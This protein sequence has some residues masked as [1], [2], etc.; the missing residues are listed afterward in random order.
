MPTIIDRWRARPSALV[1]RERSV[2]T[3]PL[4]RV[5]RRTCLIATFAGLP[6]VLLVWLSMGP[7]GFVAN[8]A[9]SLFVVFY[10][11]CVLALWSRVVSTRLAE[12]AMFL[13]VVLFA[14]AHLT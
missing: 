12:R 6:A 11:A 9:F 5:K 2:H 14:F 1:V 8:I 13:G 3:D 7:V 10:M 4:E